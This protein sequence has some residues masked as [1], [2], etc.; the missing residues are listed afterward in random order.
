MEAGEKLPPVSPVP[1]R[2]LDGI[3]KQLGALDAQHEQIVAELAGMRPQ[4][5]GLA[6]MVVLLGVS[7]VFIDKRLE[8]HGKMLTALTGGAG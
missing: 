5:L 6:L 3:R 1:P 4:F 2:E 7:L 8:G